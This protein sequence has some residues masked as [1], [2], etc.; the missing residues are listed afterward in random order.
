MIWIERGAAALA[1]ANAA[2]VVFVLVS[3]PP[4]RTYLAIFSMN[5]VSM[6]LVFVGMRLSRRTRKRQQ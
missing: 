2:V 6:I 5:T 4:G 1:V 3:R